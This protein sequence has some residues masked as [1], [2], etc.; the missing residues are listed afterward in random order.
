[1][2][3]SL[4]VIMEMFRSSNEHSE[5][6]LVFLLVLLVHSLLHLSAHSTQ[7]STLAQ[8]GFNSVSGIW[9]TIMGFC[10]RG[11]S[12]LLIF[13]GSAMQNPISFR[14]PPHSTPAIPHTLALTYPHTYTHS[15]PFAL[16]VSHCC[17]YDS[18]KLQKLLSCSSLSLP[19]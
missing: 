6:V 8:I 9:R 10:F 15:L 13:C 2:L 16:S 17:R 7:G 3:S 4:I 1:M 5:G 11:S 18:E 14:N 12:I 19:L